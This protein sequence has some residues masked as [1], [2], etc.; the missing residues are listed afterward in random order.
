M[1]C[2]FFLKTASIKEKPSP[3]NVSVTTRRND[4]KERSTFQQ[5]SAGLKFPT[6]QKNKGNFCAVTN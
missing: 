2:N 3:E 1:R 6:T 4:K 5:G